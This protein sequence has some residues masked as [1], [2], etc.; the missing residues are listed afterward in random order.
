MRDEFVKCGMNMGSTVPYL[1]EPGQARGEPPKSDARTTL[2]T[3]VSDSVFI[4]LVKL[5]PCGRG[6]EGEN[7]CVIGVKATPH[8][9]WALE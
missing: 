5:R 6:K 2:P 3:L 1:E 9:G 8:K 7:G 4:D